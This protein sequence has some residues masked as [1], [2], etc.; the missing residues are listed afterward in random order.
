MVRSRLARLLLWSAPLLAGLAPVPA[1]AGHLVGSRPKVP[2]RVVAH[3]GEAPARLTAREL[4]RIYLGRLTRWP[5]GVRVVAV[6]G[7]PESP[8]RLAVERWLFPEG[9]EALLAHWRR[10]YYQG[11]FPP[12]AFASYRAVALFVA[13][14][15][16]AIG[17]LPAGLPHPGSLEVEVVP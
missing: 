5:G 11:R 15:R 8:L 14:V 13:R 6:N 10:A 12:R 9:R 17:Y 1:G 7:P 16:G 3:P 4:R 2:F